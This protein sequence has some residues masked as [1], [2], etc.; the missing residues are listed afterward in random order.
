VPAPSERR[1]DPQQERRADEA[2]EEQLERPAAV[3]V[4][5][6][7]EDAKRAEARAGADGEQAALNVRR[8][9]QRPAACSALSSVA[10]RFSSLWSRMSA[11]STMSA[12]IQFGEP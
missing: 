9:V 6:L 8:L 10:R 11:S 1:E 5:E 4:E 7:A 12:R 2:E 3:V